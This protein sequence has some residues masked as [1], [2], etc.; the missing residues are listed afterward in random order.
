[1]QES[2]LIAVIIALVFSLS[3]GGTTD[4]L[5]AALPRDASETGAADAPPPPRGEAVPANGDGRLSLAEFRPLVK[6][7]RAFQQSQGG[8]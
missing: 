2:S 4:V 6:E 1:M 5:A 3:G 8:A 7:L